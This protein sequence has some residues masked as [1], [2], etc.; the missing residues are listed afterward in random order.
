MGIFDAW[1]PW[2]LEKQNVLSEY[3]IGKMRFLIYG[4]NEYARIIEVR[5]PSPPSVPVSPYVLRLGSI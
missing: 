1:K 5:R 3:S 4:P 2:C